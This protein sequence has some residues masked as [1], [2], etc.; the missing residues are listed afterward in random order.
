MKVVLVA[1]GWENIALQALSAVLKKGGHEVELVY[2]QALFDDKNYLCIKWLARLFDQKDLVLQRIIELEPDLVGFHVQAVQHQ[3]MREL[4][5]SVKKY[6]RVPVIFG[7]I[8][9]HSAPESVLLKD[10]AAVD[11]ICQSEGEYPLLELCDSMEKGRVDYTIENLWFRL[12][13]GEII[14]NSTRPLIDDLDGLPTIDKELFAPHFPMHYSYL[15][16]PSRGC[17][18]SCN[19]CSLQFL[20]KEAKRLGGLR[21]RE[22]SVD[23]LL[24]ELKKHVARYNPPYVDFRQPVMSASNKWIVEFFTRYKDEIGLPFRCFTHPRL[25]TED[26]VTAM[27]KAGCFAIQIGVECWDEEIRNVVLNRTES[28]D[29]IKAAAE[30][31]ERVG[32]PYAYDYILGIPRLPK[33]MSDGTTRPLDAEETYA[34]F[35][36]ELLDFA[37]FIAPLK[38][39]YRIAPFMLQ[40]MPGT[41]IIDFGVAAGDLDP[42]EL[43]RM[44]DGLQENYMAGGSVARDNRRLRLL[45]GYRVMFRLM[46]FLPSWGKK[47]LLVLRAYKIFWMAPFRVFI[48]VLDL[49]IAVRDTDARAYVFNYGWWIRKRFDPNYHLYWFKKRKTFPEVEAPFELP[50]DGYL[51]RSP[52]DEI[53]ASNFQDPKT[54][55]AE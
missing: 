6:C 2:D 27:K 7:G 51:K 17:P 35:E 26:G 25:V 14:K 33:K 28:N 44:M 39:C 24:S 10:E 52:S 54:V 37:A 42:Y 13:G 31:L 22:R 3:E 20:A 4:A 47:L 9:P 16:C 41:D 50:R 30:I 29:D 32:Q 49:M 38:Y 48:T 15:S 53:S 5:A 1:I 21:V 45:N 46:S 34:S 55:A 11:I 19:F 40:Y 18:Y 8:H 23:S 12:E 43:E 36:R